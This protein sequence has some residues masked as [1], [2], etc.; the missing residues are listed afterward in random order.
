[1]FKEKVIYPILLIVNCDLF[2]QKTLI[3]IIRINPILSLFIQ[4]LDCY[5]FQDQIM[6]VTKDTQITG[7][8][9]NHERYF[10]TK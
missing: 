8:I 1:M 4:M 10:G 7:S 3:K 6:S 5:H 9:C 2:Y